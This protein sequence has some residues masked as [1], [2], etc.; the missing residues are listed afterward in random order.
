MLVDCH[1]NA[2]AARD[3]H[4]PNEGRTQVDEHLSRQYR[5]ISL[6]NIAAWQQIYRK[7]YFSRPPTRAGRV[8]ALQTTV[9]SEV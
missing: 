6:V 9:I 1:A 2:L 7:G 5:Y 8:T 3:H 4:G